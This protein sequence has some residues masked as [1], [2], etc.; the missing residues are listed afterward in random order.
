MHLCVP[1]TL[2]NDVRSDDCH[3]SSLVTSQSNFTAFLLGS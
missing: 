3:Q 1:K 2:A